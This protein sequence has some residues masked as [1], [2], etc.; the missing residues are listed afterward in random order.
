M[1]R[2]LSRCTPSLRIARRRLS[3]I[4]RTGVAV[5]GVTV[6][7]R[8]HEVTLKL[9]GENP[10][11]AIKDRTARALIGALAD[12]GHLGSGTTIVESSSGNLAV[13]L[14]SLAP[15]LGVSACLVVDPHVA[16]SKLRRIEREGARVVMVDEP[17]AAG[18]YLLSRLRTVEQLIQ[19]HAGHVW[20]DQYASAA[21]PRAHYT[22]T[23]PEL[24]AQAPAA[25]AVFVPVSTGGT[26][27]GTA[28][29]YARYAPATAVIG[30]DVP[31]SVALGGPA[32]PRLLP[33][34]GSSQQSRFLASGGAV[35]HRLVAEARAIA[36]CHALRTWTGISV[37][38]SSGAALAAC[39]DHLAA[40]PDT[41]SVAVLCPDGGA[42]Y[43]QTIYAPDWLARHGID[44]THTG[45]GPIERI[46]RVDSAGAVAPRGRRS[47]RPAYPDRTTTTSLRGAAHA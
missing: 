9:E 43:E 25:D 47:R 5:V 42:D 19:E 29:Y 16:P 44:L 10:C 34:L 15:A 2:R 35:P 11:G 46:R 33:G 26:L 37:G 20:T 18:G 36:C 8:E 7:G 6:A 38:G 39:A 13:A 17:D 31:G 32:G 45:V 12:A 24:H 27:A 41:E 14:A 3:A 30:V 28:A 21:N 4:G 23:A 1:S 22:G 40:F